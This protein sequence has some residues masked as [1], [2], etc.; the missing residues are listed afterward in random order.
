MKRK[1]FFH[2]P[3]KSERTEYNTTPSQESKSFI[4]G[5]PSN[6]LHT[7]IKEANNFSEF[8]K[9]HK[10]QIV[11]LPLSE[12]LRLLLDEKGLKRSDVVVKTGL[13]KAYVYQIF[14]G[15]KNPS[16]DKLIT[17]ALG[18]KLNEMETQT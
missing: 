7:Q 8:W 14:S 9:R 13:D 2:Y 6:A 18:M 5:I 3:R 16:R 17:I 12:Y 11:H 10:K 15:K 1:S 4:K